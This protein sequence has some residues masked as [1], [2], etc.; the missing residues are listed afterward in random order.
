MGVDLYYAIFC[1]FVMIAA[2]FIVYDAFMHHNQICIL[3]ICMS[4]AIAYVDDGNKTTY[5]RSEQE[6]GTDH[7]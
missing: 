3:L 7:E 2:G 4:L 6:K 5:V 1:T